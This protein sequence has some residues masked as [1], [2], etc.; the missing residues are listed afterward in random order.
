MCYGDREL[1]LGAAEV[2]GL[3]WL[4]KGD[5]FQI[6]GEHSWWVN[7][8]V[9]GV[10]YYFWVGTELRKMVLDKLPMPYQSPT[11]TR[12]ATTLSESLPS[13]GEAPKT[14]V[15]VSSGGTPVFAKP[16]PKSLFPREMPKKL[17]L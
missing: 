10:I 12:T 16:T 15:N 13:R 9:A 3:V 2:A 14:L 7:P 11:P 1:V 4:F 6:G 8:L 17:L 5:K